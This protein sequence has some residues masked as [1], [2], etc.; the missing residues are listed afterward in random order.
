MSTRRNLLLLGIVAAPLIA[1]GFVAQDRS[2]ADGAKLLDQVLTIVSNRF[3]DTVEAA[4][5]Y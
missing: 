1:G 5:L 3:V 2:T 4:S